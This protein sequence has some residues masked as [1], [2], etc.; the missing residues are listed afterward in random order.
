MPIVVFGRQWHGVHSGE[1]QMNSVWGL[2]IRVLV[3]W[4]AYPLTWQGRG[5]RTVFWCYQLVARRDMNACSFW[6]GR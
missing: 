4:R 6:H 2:S 3:D 1:Y 5:Q